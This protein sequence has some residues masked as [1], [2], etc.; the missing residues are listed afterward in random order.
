MQEEFEKA[1]VVSIDKQGANDL[2]GVSVKYQD[3]TLK[4]ISGSD[5]GKTI[6][7]ENGGQTFITDQQLVT[8][9]ETLILDKTQNGI[10]ILDKYRLD[11]LPFLLI[12]FAI[13]FL[14]VAGKKGVGSI[15]GII[16][17]LGVILGFIV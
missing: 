9:G 10:V 7:L 1:E 17:S 11:T 3:L 12:G 13:L 8:V 15:L 16:I 5:T 6:K 2:D 4:I 14:A